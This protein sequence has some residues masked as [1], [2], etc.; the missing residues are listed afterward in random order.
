MGRSMPNRCGVFYLSIVAA[1][2]L[3]GGMEDVH[4]H[5]NTTKG[6]TV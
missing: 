3:L 4:T 1:S 5:T 2:T 6:A